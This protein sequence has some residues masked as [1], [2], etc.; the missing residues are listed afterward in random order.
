MAKANEGNSN[1]QGD[2][3]EGRILMNVHIDSV[4]ADPDRPNIRGKVIDTTDLQPSIREH[5]I[6]Q[7][8]LVRPVPGEDAL[9]YRLAG[10][11]RQVAARAVGLKEIPV[12]VGE[13][14]EERDI[15]RIM[16]ASDLH[17]REPH[18]VLDGDGNV[19]AGKCKAV[20]EE[21][22]DPE[23]DIDFQDLADDLGVSSDVVGAYFALYTDLPEIQEKVSRGQMAITV[24]ALIKHHGEPVKRYLAE[25]KGRVSANYVR[26]TLK[27]WKER[28]E[29]Q[30]SAAAVEVATDKAQLSMFD[31]ADGAGVEDAGV[32]DA[33]VTVGSGT[34]SL[35]VTKKM[36]A[37]Q[38]LNGAFD[39]LNR[40]K[41]HEQR[42][43]PTEW[44]ILL[45]IKKI[46]GEFLDAD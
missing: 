5:G 30:R 15:R 16:F 35:K 37:T 44:A 10:E 13:D 3:V 21:I 40:V 8:L 23:T 36:N 41:I 43:G 27:E 28:I 25:K 14:L 4:I 32:E 17:K 9:W 46:V 33:T 31:D 34:V 2:S 39:N 24:Y 42:L 18:I 19:I 22:S 12:I 1:V 26:T 29:P 38:L 6:L 20:Y 45:Q 11:R 7:P